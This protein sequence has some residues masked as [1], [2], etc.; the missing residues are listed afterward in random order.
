MRI[1]IP[2]A[3][4]ELAS[5]FGH[6]EEFC[7]FDVSGDEGSIEDTDAQSPPPHRP[8]VLPEWL[9]ENETDV[10]IAGGMGRRAQQLFSEAGINVVVG[11]TESEPRSL[12]RSYLED[13]LTTGENPCSH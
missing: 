11:A 3:D 9:K 1:A 7:F 4:G 13:A 5:H 6:C 12:V 10:V 8:G 2:V